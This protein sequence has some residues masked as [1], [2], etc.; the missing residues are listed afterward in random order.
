V[1]SNPAAPTAS[2][3]FLLGDLTL[4]ALYDVIPTGDE[5][6][7]GHVIFLCSPMWVTGLH[8]AAVRQNF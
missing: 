5:R 1:G 6:P 8:E 2:S 3:A 7:D 4:D